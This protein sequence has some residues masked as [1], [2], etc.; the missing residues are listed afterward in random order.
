MEM[1]LRWYGS[2]FDTVTLE[3]IRQI[4]GVTGV[5]TT[6]YDTAPGDVWTQIW[7]AVTIDGKSA[8]EAINEYYPAL[9]KAFNEANGN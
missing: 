4:P 5:I 2:K 8:D 6:L 3:Q 1:T 9:E 7:Q